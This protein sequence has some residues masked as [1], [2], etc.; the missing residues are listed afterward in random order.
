MTPSFDRDL[1]TRAPLLIVAATAPELAPLE[2]ALEGGASTAIGRAARPA[3]EGLV[4]GR[5]VLLL[6]C[7]LGKSNAAQALTAVLETRAVSSV[8][9]VGVG[10]AYPGKRL[11]LTALTVASEEIFADEGVETPAGFL[12]CEL[13]GESAH[14]H[15]GLT[16]SPNRV[17]LDPLLVRAAQE[18][19]ARAGRPVSVGPFATV[20]TCSGTDLAAARLRERWGALVE[21][22]E[23]AALAATALR[24]GVPLLELRSISNLVQNRD[25]SSWDLEGAIAAAAQG[26]RLILPGLP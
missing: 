8:L 20:S 19:L 6:A 17:P 9:A 24:Y 16:G 12:G 22:M 18:H 4:D 5:E 15:P 1:P 23:G 14:G 11:P 26:A 21:S 2:A 7:G 10:G 13:I 25:R 3:H